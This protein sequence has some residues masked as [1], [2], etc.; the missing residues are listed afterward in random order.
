MFTDSLFLNSFNRGTAPTVKRGTQK[1]KCLKKR[2]FFKLLFR[3][4][5]NIQMRIKIQLTC[6]L[7]INVQRRS[8]CETERVRQ[9]ECI[10]FI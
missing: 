9:G 6:D 7:K 4:Q 8:V 1:Q 10:L 5:I 2:N 3:E